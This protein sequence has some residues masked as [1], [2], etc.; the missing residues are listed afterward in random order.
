MINDVITIYFIRHA[1][2]I[3]NEEKR[4]CG[5]TN[6]KLSETGKEQA[7]QLGEYMRDIPLDIIYSS[8]LIRTYDTAKGIQ[9]NHEDFIPIRTI[10]NFKEVDFGSLDGFTHEL[11]R[12]CFPKEMND[13]TFVKRY[14]EGLPKQESIEDAQARFLD[15]LNK[16]LDNTIY[17]S[18]CIVTH[19]TVLRSV[20]ASFLNYSK[21]E[22]RNI[23]SF[24]NASITK[25]IYDK[26][27]KQ[28]NVEYIGH[29]KP[30]E[31][32]EA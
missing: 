21:D 12:E 27:S 6:F 28:F 24:P 31:E 29:I 26:N 25:V 19:G 16:V 7:N 13:W 10:S 3:G 1:E 5:R 20:L 32:K 18:I 11:A 17:T 14:P 15:G 22:Y 2:S 4:L 30:L 9:T 23:P 8:P